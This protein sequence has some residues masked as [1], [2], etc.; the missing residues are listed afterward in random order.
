[1]D[2]LVLLGGSRLRE[3][4]AE[5]FAAAAIH[6][7]DRSVVEFGKWRAEIEDA[8]LQQRFAWRHRKLLI[9]EMRD[10]GFAGLRHQRLAERL[11]R[12]ALMG[13]E[14]PERNAARPRLSRRHEDF[15]A[16]DR[17]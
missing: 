12:L 13:I 8:G 10:A 1:A 5:H 16:A 4:L 11:Q 15:N 2:E 17:E 6:A 14:Q 9:D 3:I 7:R